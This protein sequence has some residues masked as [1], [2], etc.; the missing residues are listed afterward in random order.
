MEE[1]NPIRT[2]GDYSNPSHEGYM[3][4]IELPVGNN[5][6]RLTLTVK[7]GKERACI[8]FNFPFAFKLE[9]GLN[10]F[11]QDPSPYG[12][13]LLL[14]SLLIS[15][16]REGFGPHDTQ[17]CMKNPKQAFVEYASSRIDE[18]R[19]LVSNFMA[20][21]DARLSK[22]EVDFKQQQSEMTKKINTVLKAISDRMAGALP[23]DTVKNLKLNVN[24][25]SPILSARS[26]PTDDR[27][28][29]PISMVQSTPSQS[30]P[31][32][33][34]TPMRTCQKR[35]RKK[36]RTTQKIL[37]PT[38]PHHMI[39]QFHSSPKKSSNLIYSLNHS[40]WS[41]NYPAHNLFAP[42]GMMVT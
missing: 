34:A 28:A 21:Q 2:L 35:M 22:F 13:I 17:Y 18:A 15:F 6:T 3:N 23:S 25:T 32:N 5:V 40:A 4:T 9:I 37:I 42:K 30:I 14:V 26:Y 41:P 8:Y 27:N 29:Q 11:Q 19:G 12:K 36:R 38:L 31:S 10:I 16:Y 7:I 24:S 1:A 39:H 20:S 33:K